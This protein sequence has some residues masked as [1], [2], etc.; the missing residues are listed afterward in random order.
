MYIKKCF[1][2]ITDLTYNNN[3]NDNYIYVRGAILLLLLYICVCVTNKIVAIFLLSICDFVCVVWGG[4]GVVS[5]DTRREK[6]STGSYSR[7]YLFHTGGGPKSYLKTGLRDD[8]K[9][10]NESQHLD[11]MR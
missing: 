1:L 9:L 6:F 5:L 8:S 11:S 10:F 3:N 7:I 4:V 2:L